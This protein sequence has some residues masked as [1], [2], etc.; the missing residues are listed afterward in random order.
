VEQFLIPHLG[1]VCLADLNIHRL[2]AGF[3]EIATTK[4]SKGVPQSASCLQHLR[5]TLRAALNFAVWEGVLAEKPGPAARSARLSRD[6][7]NNGV[8]P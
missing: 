7:K 1:E 3:A 4:N 8:T 2:R 6:C 5:T